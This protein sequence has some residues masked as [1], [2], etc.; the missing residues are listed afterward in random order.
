MLK[1]A[2]C[3]LFIIVMVGFL[4]ICFK[5]AAQPVEGYEAPHDSEYYA[6]RPEELKAELEDNLFPLLDGVIGCELEGTQLK[7]VFEEDCFAEA[8]GSI[9]YYYDRELFIFEKR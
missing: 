6:G 9:V 1:P 4:A 8:A 3:V 5:P 2:G 7:I